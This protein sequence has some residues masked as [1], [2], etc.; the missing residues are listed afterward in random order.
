VNFEIALAYL[1]LGDKEQALEWLAKAC[2][3]PDE[4]VDVKLSNFLVDFRWDSLRPDPR[5]KLLLKKLHLE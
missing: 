4:K 2:D 3:D 1:G 5:F